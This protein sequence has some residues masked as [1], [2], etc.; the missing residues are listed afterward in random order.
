MIYVLAIQMFADLL[1]FENLI[2]SF[3][4]LIRIGK[5]IHFVGLIH[6]KTHFNDVKSI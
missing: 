4:F 5:H 6:L 3:F 2:D 1:P